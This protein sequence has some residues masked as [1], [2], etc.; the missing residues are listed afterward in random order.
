MKR[1]IIVLFLFIASVAWISAQD[2]FTETFLGKLGL[3]QNKIEQILDIQST[4]RDQIKEA[5]LEMN[6]FK[7]QLE[8]ILYNVNPDMGKVKK[9]LESSLKYRLQSELAAIE[10][11]VKIRQ[12][13][14]EK[15]WD[16]MLQMKKR[17]N[18][19]NKAQPQQERKNTHGK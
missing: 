19:I 1:K 14:G 16:R 12:I 11:R 18:R 4:S 5:A 3:P 6:I 8:K 9:L 7:A 17:L 10:A 2:L 13:M 15:D